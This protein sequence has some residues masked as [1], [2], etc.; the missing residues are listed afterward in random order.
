MAETVVMG[1]RIPKTL[2]AKIVAEQRHV[3]KLTDI[4]PSLNEV[5]QMLLE[6]GLEM[7]EKKRRG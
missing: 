2:H 6:R 3:T 5:V 1:V 4:E 7:S